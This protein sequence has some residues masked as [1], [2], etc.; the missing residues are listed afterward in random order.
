M[1]RSLFIGA[2]FSVGAGLPLAADLHLLVR[3]ASWRQYGR[4]NHFERDLN[5]FIK[6]QLRC[7][8][9]VIDPDQVD[10]EE[11]L[12]FLDAEHFLGL[13]GKD[14]WSSDGNETQLMIRSAIART[15][16]KPS[17]MSLATTSTTNPTWSSEARG[18][19]HSECSTSANHRTP[20]PP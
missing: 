9:R 16:S 15:R 19:R 10:L 17:I 20:K 8:N 11:F 4:D 2:G 6:F 13:K 5:R 1:S 12:G 14:T 7:D 18:R 3:E